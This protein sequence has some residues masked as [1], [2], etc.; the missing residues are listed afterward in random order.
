MVSIRE[1][2]FSGEASPEHVHSIYMVSHVVALAYLDCPTLKWPSFF[3][4]AH[5]CL[6]SE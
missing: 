5:H 2:V 4:L 3:C 6:R 1:L